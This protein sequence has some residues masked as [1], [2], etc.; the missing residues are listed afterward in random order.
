MWFDSHSED[1]KLFEEYKKA[2]DAH[3]EFLKSQLDLMQK[4]YDE[5]L[6][7]LGVA[8]RASLPSMTDYKLVPRNSWSA[9]RERLEKKEL[10]KAEEFWK[11]KI[12][13][14]ES[15]MKLGGEDKDA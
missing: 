5:L 8:K 11:K 15:E 10:E 12:E 7:V 6:E 14:T 13:D 1:L 4:R 9:I 3:I 2:T